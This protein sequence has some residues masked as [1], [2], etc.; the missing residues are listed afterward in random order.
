MA[1]DRKTVTHRLFLREGMVAIGGSP[2]NYVVSWRPIRADH[3]DAPE[4]L[5][6]RDDEDAETIVEW[7][8]VYFE[9]RDPRDL[10]STL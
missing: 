8:R 4:L 3:P 1:P 10:L 9:R 5:V 2:G 6:A 7:A